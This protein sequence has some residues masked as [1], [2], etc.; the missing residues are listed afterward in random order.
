MGSRILHNASPPP[1]MA[2]YPVTNMSRG[3]YAVKPVRS[4]TIA[5]SAST[6][7]ASSSSSTASAQITGTTLDISSIQQLVRTVFRS[8]KLTIQQVEVFQGHL[9]QVY[10]T[11]LADGSSVVLKCPPVHNVRLLRHEKHFLETERKTLEMLSQYTQ[12]PVPQLVVYDCHGESLGRPFLMMSHMPGRRLSELGPYLTAS[13]RS[14]IDHTMGTHVRALSALSATQFGTSHR[15]FAKKGNSSW[16]E[17]FL[18]LLEA[19][20]RDAED[21]LVNTHPESIRYWIGKHAHHLDKVTEPRL[22]A[23]NVCNPENILVDEQTKQVVGL[24]G[25][26]NIIWGDPLMSGGMADASQAF[27][28]GLGEGP[29]RAGPERIRMLM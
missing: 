13:E 21:M 24:V 7:S 9:S 22:V 29:L 27:C 12:I 17:A 14:T 6:S 8:S 5:S 11:K 23:P 19:V 10:H 1:D 16:R 26:S 15:V 28:A 18:A 3:S 25:F 20:L 2:I 4:C